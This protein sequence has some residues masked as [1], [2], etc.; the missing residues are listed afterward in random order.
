MKCTKGFI[1]IKFGHLLKA[2]LSAN[3]LEIRKSLNSFYYSGSRYCNQ[4]YLNMDKSAAVTTAPVA[5][6]ATVPASL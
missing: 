2:I 3:C 6:A 1:F 5:T 4:F